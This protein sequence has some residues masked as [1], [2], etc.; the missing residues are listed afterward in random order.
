MH[1]RN[2]TRD[3]LRYLRSR[4]AL[5]VRRHLGPQPPQSESSSTEGE[6]I[7]RRDGLYAQVLRVYQSEITPLD[8]DVLLF[9][10][11]ERNWHEGY[12]VDAHLG[13]RTLVRGAL[14]VH[15][16]PGDHLGILAEPNVVRLAR[17]LQSRL[18]Q[19]VV[20]GALRR[21]G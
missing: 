11:Q 13:W 1:L 3:P 4:I 9:R 14:E 10:S 15:D 18:D 12:D 19:E 7:E 5:R 21:A 17:I 2:L 20:T 6:L 8:G 16:I